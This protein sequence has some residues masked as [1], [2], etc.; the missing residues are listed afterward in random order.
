MI[1]KCHCTSSS[2]IF[3]CRRETLAS[4]QKSMLHAVHLAATSRATACNKVLEHCTQ[5]E[6]PSPSIWRA[7]GQAVVAVP[8]AEVPFYT[9]IPT[10][11]QRRKRFLTLHCSTVTH[12]RF[13]RQGLASCCN[14]RFLAHAAIPDSTAVDDTGGRGAGSD[15][16]VSAEPLSPLPPSSPPFTTAGCSARSHTDLLNKASHL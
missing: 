3:A 12:S 6:T 13:L 4:E 8:S 1:I 14:G 9:Y 15:L 10:P 7:W 11:A 16:A 5:L 2:S